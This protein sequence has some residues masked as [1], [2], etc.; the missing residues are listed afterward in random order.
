MRAQSGRREVSET[1]IIGAEA[2][3][4]KDELEIELNKIKKIIFD[5]SSKDKIY[6][7]KLICR[8]ENSLSEV[9]EVSCVNGNYIERKVKDLKGE[10]AKET[11]NGK[12]Y[13]YPVYK[14]GEKPEF[15][16]LLFTP[17]SDIKWIYQMLME[18]TIEVLLSLYLV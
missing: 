17:S 11:I 18:C 10:I 16:I 2:L 13:N 14:E 5:L 3:K 1:E 4:T 8:F 9:H 12:D 7:A 6:Y 15:G